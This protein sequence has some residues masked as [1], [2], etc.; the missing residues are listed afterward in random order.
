MQEGGK[1][2][3][4]R[5]GNPEQGR[6]TA[7]RATKLRRR[8]QR[9]NFLLLAGAVA[10]LLLLIF[11]VPKWITG[12]YIFEPLRRATYSAG[13][14]SG[15]VERRMEVRKPDSR[16]GWAASSKAL[17]SAQGMAVKLPP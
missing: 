13:T 4:K 10:A 11:E 16:K 6:R 8:K 5:T 14:A 17:C 12:S 2:V 1:P 15:L 9:M 7:S 3:E